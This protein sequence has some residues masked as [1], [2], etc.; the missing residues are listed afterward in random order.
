MLTDDMP[1]APSDARSSA[2]FRLRA[3]IEAERRR[4]RR[5]RSRGRVIVCAVV[6]LAVLGLS[7]V[8]RNGELQPLIGLAD[9]IAASPPPLEPVVRHWYTRTLRSELVE[10][11]PAG[12]G[13]VLRFLV[14]AV[15]ET[16]HDGGTVPFRTTRYLDPVFLSPE[17]ERRFQAAGLDDEY[18]AGLVATEHVD[19]SQLA[20]VDRVARSA[21]DELEGMLRRSVAGLGDRR[22]EEVH[23]LRLTADLMQLHADDPI[24]RSQ[25]LR[26]RRWRPP[27]PAGIRVRRPHRASR[28]R[29]ARAAGRSERRTGV[30]PVVGETRDDPPDDSRGE[31]TREPWDFLGTIESERPST[32]DRCARLES[33]RYRPVTVMSS[34]FLP[35]RRGPASGC[36]PPL[37][38]GVAP[39]QLSF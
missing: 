39:S 29:V 24:V 5:G 37:R 8:G 11:D 23:L 21:P 27:A 13:D 22:L 14:P 10:V 35:D 17:D 26:L 2:R 1:D 38:V 28:G 18:T 16:W 7:P 15:E 19:F 9:A 4:R 3:R 33:S 25:L 30:R 34:P 6:I 32:S 36:R 20:F 12:T 31:L